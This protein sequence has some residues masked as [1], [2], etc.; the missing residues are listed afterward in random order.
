MK[1]MRIVEWYN[2]I[3]ENCVPCERDLI[4]KEILEIDNIIEKVCSGRI[5]WNNYDA[6]FIEEFYT[7]LRNLHSRVLNAQNNIKKIQNSIRSWGQ[8]P[9]YQRKDGGTEGLLDIEDRP[10]KVQRRLEACFDTKKL[11]DIAMD[12]NFRYYFDMFVESEEKMVSEM[13]VKSKGTAESLAVVKKSSV[14]VK[15]EEAGGSSLVDAAQA[16][17]SL[18][19]SELERTPSQLALFKPYQKYVDSLVSKEILDAIHTSIRYIKFEM[20]N[21]LEHNAPIF[22]IKYELNPPK[23]RFVPTLD[24]FDPLGFLSL[25]EGLLTDIYCMSTI[26]RIVQPLQIKSSIKIEDT[27]E[28]Q[29]SDIDQPHE[30]DDSEET[31]EITLV[32]Y[33]GKLN[34]YFEFQPTPPTPTFRFRSPRQ[35]P[36]N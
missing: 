15:T 33:L 9:M 31:N 4:Q 26:P 29:E 16:K 23:T 30:T 25:V 10:D 7:K 27:N 21:R 1:L 19:H 17:S 36:G 13:S 32:T 2:E 35:R 24:P 28:S 6:A 3:I 34:L 11:I 5:D 20:E 8:V 22:E 14:E 12:Q 18:E